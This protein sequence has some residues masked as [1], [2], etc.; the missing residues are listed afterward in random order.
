MIS[1]GVP[2]S[3][4]CNDLNPRVD[5]NRFCLDFWFGISLQRLVKCMARSSTWV[6]IADTH[7]CTSS[8]LS[9]SPR[10][11]SLFARRL[12]W[13]EFEVILM[14]SQDSG[15][16]RTP[17]LILRSRYMDTI[18]FGSIVVLLDNIVLLCA[19][20]FMSTSVLY[21]LRWLEEEFWHI[22]A[23]IFTKKDW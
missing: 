16:D 18:E 23:M 13:F 15:D 11:T 2:S 22:Y 5:E 8:F 4:V 6:P 3:R 20:D 12:P 10:E 17:V 14:L 21:D 7:C 9:K 1:R 19:A